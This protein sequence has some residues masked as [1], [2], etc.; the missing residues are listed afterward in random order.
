ME[1]KYLEP[2]DYLT[3]P[4]KNK[5]KRT[6]FHFNNETLCKNSKIRTLSKTY[7]FKIKDHHFIEYIGDKYH[8][9]YSFNEEMR[10]EDLK[11][12]LMFM[13]D[14]WEFF[15]HF[16]YN[17]IKVM[18]EYC[19]NLAD[20]SFDFRHNNAMLIYKVKKIIKNGPKT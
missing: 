20:I 16:E 11:K 18:L 10:Y 2:K 14:R 7:D 4:T 6:I 9:H 12:F 13:N 15:E 17:F 19:V 1:H 5:Q 8:Y 3:D